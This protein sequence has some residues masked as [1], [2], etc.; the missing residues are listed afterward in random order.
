MSKVQQEVPE[1]YSTEDNRFLDIS[2]R[3]PFLTSIGSGW[4]DINL[5]SFDLPAAQMLEYSLD[6]YGIGINIGQ[7][8]QLERVLEGT[9]QQGFLPP[10]GSCLCPSYHHQAYRWDRR[11]Q[12]IYLNLAP[13]LLSLQA[14]ALLKTD[15]V[16]V[17]PQFAVQDQLIYQIGLALQAELRSQG[18]GGCL[19]A[20]TMA[21]ALAVHILRHYSSQGHRILNYNGGVAQHKLRL[22]IDYINDNLEHELSLKELA[23][24]AQMSQYHFCRAF[25]QAT[26]LSPHQY[27]IQQR[28][29]RA[30]QL[31][32][33]GGMSL[34]AV[35]IA[36][37]FTHQSH[38]HRHFKRL[39]GVTP[40][41][42]LNS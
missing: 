4:S 20:E 12:I 2:E 29:E 13:E 41:T 16:E 31:L 6:Q 25:K 17:I 36:C 27:L 11:N 3:S 21:N 14:T 42:F 9:L 39:T 18:S 15:C 1:V 37:G 35:A 33:K 32:Q 10:G 19:Y 8:F 38:L 22:V 7:G 26:R 34:G 40:K 5:A 30:K 24:I 28:V 23:A